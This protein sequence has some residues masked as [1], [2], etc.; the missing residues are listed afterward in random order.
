MRVC[1]HCSLSLSSLFMQ[2]RLLLFVCYIQY[3]ESNKISPRPLPETH[4][5]KSVPLYVCQ[6]GYRYLPCIK[7]DTMQSRSVKSTRR[8]VFVQVKS[9]R[10]SVPV[11]IPVV[12]EREGS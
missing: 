5:Q 12:P 8:S 11:R 6:S 2:R 7:F 9:Q 1:A 3:T 10:N 4:M